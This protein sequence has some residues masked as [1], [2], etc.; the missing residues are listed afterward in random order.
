MFMILSSCKLVF[1][2]EQGAPREGRGGPEVLRG[3]DLVLGLCEGRKRLWEDLTGFRLSLPA[4]C[5][6]QQ[7]HK[8]LELL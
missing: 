3:P 4:I 5:E 6:K 2:G 7:D 8:A 1:W